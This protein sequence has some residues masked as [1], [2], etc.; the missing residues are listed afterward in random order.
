MK[1]RV[2]APPLSRLDCLDEAG[3]AE[4]PEG[5]SLKDLLKLLGLPLPSGFAR[6]CLVNRERAEP[7]KVLREGD[8]VAFFAIVGGG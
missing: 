3:M 1:I 4:L 6:L 7:G 8:S 5:A 2:Y